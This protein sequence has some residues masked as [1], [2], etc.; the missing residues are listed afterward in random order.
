[1]NLLTDKLRQGFEI[2]GKFYPVNTDFR[3]WI[4][5]LEAL[6]DKTKEGLIKALCLCY[7]VLPPDIE[8]AISKMILFLSSEN[9][10]KKEKKGQKL[11][12]LYEDSGL[13]LSSFLM[14]YN[15]NLINEEMHWYVF[16]SLV[17]ALPEDT[18]FSR[19]IYYRSVD[20]TEI[21]SKSKR[22]FFRKMKK[23]YAL[24]SVNKE[25]DAAFELGGAFEI[26][27]SG[28]KKN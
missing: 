26:E 28:R 12:D 19:A 24:K 1:M 16:C 21:K 18:P 20:L 15:I 8:Q 27:N 3:V 13:I 6:K 23:L 4:E 10:E 2:D 11:Y 17:S 22:Q 7:K 25:V 14:A 5:I 9:I